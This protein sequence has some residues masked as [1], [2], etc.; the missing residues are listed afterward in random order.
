MAPDPLDQR[1]IQNELGAALI[2]IHED[3]YGV[4]AASTRVLVDGDAIVVFFDGLELQQ[5]E[6]LLIEGGFADSVLAQ[7]SDFQR[8]IARV[9]RGG[10]K[11]Q[12]LA[13]R[14]LRQHHQAGTALLGRDLPRH[15]AASLR[16]TGSWR[17]SAWAAG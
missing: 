16:G 15:A 11:S 12:W 1:A 17:L 6:T 8:A 14:L 7:R 10:G 9:P 4:G 2:Q 5:N 13:R 3:S